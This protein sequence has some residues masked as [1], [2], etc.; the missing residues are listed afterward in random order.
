MQVTIQNEVIVYVSQGARLD[1][2]HYR[3]TK[4]IRTIELINSPP[5]L[6]TSVVIS[7]YNQKHGT[8]VK[9][10][11]VTQTALPYFDWTILET[12]LT[13]EKPLN[14]WVDAVDQDKEL[15]FYGN[16]EML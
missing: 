15:L 5:K 6:L 11:T 7:V 13:T 3:N 8:L 9:S 14:Y 10:W 2:V 4:T 12:D 16:F 1:I